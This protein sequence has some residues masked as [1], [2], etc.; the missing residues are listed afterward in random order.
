LTR[1]P[2]SD[3]N[4]TYGVALRVYSNGVDELTA[5]KI[6]R[7]LVRAYARKRRCG[8]VCETS[9][10]ERLQNRNGWQRTISALANTKTADIGNTGRVYL[11]A[12]RQSDDD[13]AEIWRVITLI[14]CGTIAAMVV[15]AWEWFNPDTGRTVIRSTCHVALPYGCCVWR[16]YSTGALIG[17]VAGNG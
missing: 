9:A 2:K 16:D 3:A 6:S 13:A 5:N 14:S 15:S 1:Q 11:V 7:A 12:M 17:I 8:A 10:I 4:R